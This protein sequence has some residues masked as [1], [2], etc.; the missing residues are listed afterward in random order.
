MSVRRVVV[1]KAG[2]YDR[3]VIETRTERKPGRGEITIDVEAIGV[4]CMDE[5]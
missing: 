4:N 3:L 5:R 1:H 2:S